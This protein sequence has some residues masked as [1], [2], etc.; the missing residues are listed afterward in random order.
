MTDKQFIA[1]LRSSDE[2]ECQ[3]LTVKT[4]VNQA[5]RLTTAKASLKCAFFEMTGSHTTEKC[6]QIKLAKKAQSKT[7]NNIKPNGNIKD[8]KIRSMATNF[9]P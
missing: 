9:K 2:N 7:K 1:E 6:R 8:A 5:N 3:D 4:N